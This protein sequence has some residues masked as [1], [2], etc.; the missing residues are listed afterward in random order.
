M[1]G[2]MRRQ[3]VKLA[4]AD[5][6]LTKHEHSAFCN[7]VALATETSDWLAGGLMAGAVVSAVN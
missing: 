1:D 5:A 3:Q 6:S 4:F 7:V 2:E